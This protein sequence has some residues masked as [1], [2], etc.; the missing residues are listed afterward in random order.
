MSYFSF[1]KFRMLVSDVSQAVLSYLSF[2]NIR[3]LV[4]DATH[5]VSPC[6]S[7]YVTHAVSP[8]FSFDATLVVESLHAEQGFSTKHWILL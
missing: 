2:E 1:E 8:S 6:L 4:S 5:V 7:S 3:M